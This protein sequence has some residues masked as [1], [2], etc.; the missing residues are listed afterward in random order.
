MTE[1]GYLSK[2]KIKSNTK[3]KL[4]KLTLVSIDPDAKLPQ[5]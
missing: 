1:N 3:I 4:T 2:E 5:T